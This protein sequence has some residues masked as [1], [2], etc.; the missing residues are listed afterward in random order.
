VNSIPPATGKFDVPCFGGLSHAV[1]N[2]GSF[3][4]IEGSRNGTGAALAAQT[5]LN[6]G[7]RR[8]QEF[9]LPVVALRDSPG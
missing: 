5:A 9:A 2:Q 6:G 8:A 1:I 7:P 3:G 4:E